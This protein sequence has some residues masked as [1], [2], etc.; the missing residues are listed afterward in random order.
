MNDVTCNDSAKFYLISTDL[1]DLRSTFIANCIFNNFLTHTS[2]MLNIVT[3][4]AIHKT[5]AIAKTLK[6]LLLSLACSDV[7]VGLFSQPLYT[8]FLVKWL[9][10]DNLNCNIYQALNISGY[11]FSAVSFLGVVALSVDRF[12]AVHLHLRYQEL[13]TQKRV[14]VVVISKWLC[15]AFVSSIALWGLPGA[16]SIT[17]SVVAVFGFIVTF[18]VYTRIYLTVRRHKNQIHSMQ[19]MQIRNEAQSEEIKNFNILIRSTAG[20]FYV[21]LVFLIC[22]LPYFICKAVIQI[23]GSSIVLKKLYLYSLTLVFLNSSLNP[24]IYCWKMKH[25]RH[26]IIDI[27]GK[28]SWISNRPFRINYN[29]SS[30]VVHIDN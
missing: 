5:S 6:T 24:V 29:R 3:I 14:V 16:R 9:Q 7:A 26:T 27:L 4:Y 18:V 15:S 11:L 2:I 21:Y 8:F 23:Y 28:M 25:I 10:L 20:I 12:L 19:S 30:N 13:V 22:Y 1:K 17:K